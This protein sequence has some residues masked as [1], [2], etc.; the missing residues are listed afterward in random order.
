MLK[1]WLKP[2]E[3]IVP[4]YYPLYFKKIN[5][6]AIYLP[7]VDRFLLADTFDPWITLEV[8]EILSSKVPT[9]VI[10]LGEGIPGLSNLTV[11][12]HTIR[13]KTGLVIHGANI[14]VARQTPLV[15]KIQ[16]EG[17]I[18]NVGWSDDYASPEKRSIL[19]KLQEYGLFCLRICHALKITESMNNIVPHKKYIEDYFPGMVP[20]DFTV[21]IDQTEFPHGLGREIKQILYMADSVTDALTQI[22][23][24]WLEYSQAIPRIRET[25]YKI[26]GIE[27]PASLSVLAL[28]HNFTV[29]AV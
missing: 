16:G 7:G 5:G 22:E 15:R 4:A 1:S 10:L 18:I 12:E 24:A 17:S 28:K 6:H 14:L 25:F 3:G 13:D 19:L 2:L 27:M 26:V 21:P 8:A 29:R 11:L 23:K 9:Q 20:Q